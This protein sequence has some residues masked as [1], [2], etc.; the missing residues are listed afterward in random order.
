MSPTPNPDHLA[1]LVQLCRNPE[2]S[3]D[4][5]ASSGVD[6]FFRFLFRLL[7]EE[8]FNCTVAVHSLHLLVCVIIDDPMGEKVKLPANI[9]LF[10]CLFLYL[11]V[12]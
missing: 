9:F 5:L 3:K 10:I 2:V 12:L 4:L 11:F 6:K 1:I 7:G 8:N